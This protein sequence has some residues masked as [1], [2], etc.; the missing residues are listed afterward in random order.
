MPETLRD[1]RDTLRLRDAVR[2]QLQGLDTTQ[3]QDATK[4]DKRQER[5][6]E[7]MR[8]LSKLDDDVSR[9]RQALS[10]E[11]ERSR[12][13][14][15]EAEQS[16]RTLEERLRAG[17]I[18]DAIFQ[19]EERSLRNQ[20]RAACAH[21]SL[22]ESVCTAD[23]AQE[24]DG[25]RTEAIANS[26]MSASDKTDALMR[27]Y[28]EGR[29]ADWPGASVPE[30]LGM[31]WRD[32][33][34]PR[35]RRPIL[36]STGI[37]A[38]LT[39]IVIGV[40]MVSGASRDSVTVFLGQDEVLVPV[41]AENADTVRELEFTIE[42]DPGMVTGI[43]VVQGEVGRLAVM[44]YDF[45]RAGS[46]TV[47]VRDV[48][49]VSGTGELLIA[50]FRTRPDA[51]GQAGLT[52]TSIE[53]IHALTGSVIPVHGQDGWIDTDNLDVAAPVLQFAAP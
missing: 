25:R 48:V 15:S 24:M 39:L 46:L 17:D 34:K 10:D 12:T 44:Q 41:I 2:S 43:S 29:P 21:V 1:L 14:L 49:G 6:S 20:M 40:V 5:R 9:L 51:A 16:L 22:V 42:Y 33:K 4:K 31:V 52:F 37:I 11:A 23:T 13:D 19:K 18:T 27:R 30:R 7:L 35:S 32:G 47:T 28:T 36:I 38:A 53:A 50:R 3:G 26:D 45:D 8:R